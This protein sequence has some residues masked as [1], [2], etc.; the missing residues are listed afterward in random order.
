MLVLTLALV[1]TAVLLVRV[2]YPGGF[3]DANLEAMS[4]Q[5]VASYNA[6]QPASSH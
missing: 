6:S 2:R 4:H 5:W 1:L 3:H